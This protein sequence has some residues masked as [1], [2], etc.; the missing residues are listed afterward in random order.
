M[1]TRPD[2]EVIMTA[3]SLI[4]AV[5]VGVVVGLAGRIVVC[6]GRDLPW[7]LPAAAGVA[8]AVM[9]TVITWMVDAD[10]SGPTAIEVLLQALAAAAG[11]TIVAVT[12][13]RAAD[14]TRWQPR[15]GKAN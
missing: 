10:R 5:T 1:N 11:V 13:D 8:A 14:E 3:D 15:G 9:M 2:V 6:R 12:A 4:I 7:W